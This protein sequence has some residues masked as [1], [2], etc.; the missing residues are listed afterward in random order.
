MKKSKQG[1]WSAFILVFCLLL[2]I[3]TEAAPK[4]P[5]T[6]AEL[7]LYKGADRQQ[8]L[9]EGARKEG[10]ITFYTSGI[11]KLAVRPVVD[12][13]E[14]KYPFLKVMIWR[15]T[16]GMELVPRVTMESMPHLRLSL[17]P[18]SLEHGRQAHLWPGR[19]WNRFA[20]AWD[21]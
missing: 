13:F 21:R 17:I 18:T 7:A 20:P 10:T 1:Y 11:L 12:A 4:R 16:G 14:K 8:I 3:L 5:D 6:M 2:P 15:A 19:H 9:E